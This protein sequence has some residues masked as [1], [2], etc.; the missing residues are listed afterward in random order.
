MSAPMG[1]LE[2]RMPSPG[3]PARDASTSET[4][5]ARRYAH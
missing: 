4:Q 2:K 3:T 5:R 1:A